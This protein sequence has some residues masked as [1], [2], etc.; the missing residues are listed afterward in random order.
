MLL[1]YQEN[2]RK[3]ISMAKKDI[4]T[5]QYMRNPRRFADFFNGLIF[6]GKQVIDYSLLEEI[7]TSMLS[8]IPYS[9]KKGHKSVQ[10]FR[11]I[12]K[13][14]VIMKADKGYFALLGIENQSDIHYAMPVKD[15]LYDALT[16]QN[17]V[18]EIANYNRKNGYC[19]SQEF[20]SGFRKE[21][22]LIPV[23]TVT[24]YWGSDSWNGPLSIRDMLID[25]DPA[26]RKY[27]NDYKINLFSI[28]DKDKFPKFHTELRELFLILNARNDSNKMK[29]LVQG[30]KSF[31]HIERDTAELISDFASVS[32]PRVNKEGDF[33]MCKAVMDIK[34][35][36][37]EEGRLEGRE[38]GKLEV[39]ASLVKDG[40]LEVEEAAKR[41]GIS[42]EE[43]KA[44]L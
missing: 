19:T 14:S 26:M 6:H 41:A 11:D 8:V 21:D 28:I 15:M 24:I 13:K 34:Q 33:D 35:E 2:Y 38:E 36:G 10:K 7:D 25:I 30:D 9:K 29:E 12:I 39:L 20:T 42:V 17:Q 32:L 3:E 27:V 37:R 44:Y 22:K 43:M 40:L 16:Y 31:R 5:K 18:D 1:S 4:D 23:I